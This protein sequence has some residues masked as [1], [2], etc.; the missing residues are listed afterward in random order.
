MYVNAMSLKDEF[1]NKV[2]TKHKRLDRSLV[3]SRG[4]LR[5]VEKVT[6]PRRPCLAVTLQV[7]HNAQAPNNLL[8][9]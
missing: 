6:S 3:V 8:I 2:A 9:R 5:S 1:Y 7:Q 4:N